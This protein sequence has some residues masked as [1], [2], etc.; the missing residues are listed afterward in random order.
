MSNDHIKQSIETAIA[1]LTSHPDEARYTDSAAVAT[2]QTGLR[3][4]V[5]DPDGRAIL[6]DMP[7]GVGGE[8]K[9]PSPGWLFRAALASCVGSLA[10]MRAAQTGVALSK[11]QVTVDSQSDDRGILGID[12][13]IHAGP[14]SVRVS[15]KIESKDAGEELIRELSEWAL[16]HCPVA[17][18]VGSEVEVKLEILS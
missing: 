2:L 7:K 18:A 10:A 14:L 5:T 11:L 4:K 9:E 16:E 17:D 3:F 12:E 1:Y 6:T 13:K 8:G 15:V